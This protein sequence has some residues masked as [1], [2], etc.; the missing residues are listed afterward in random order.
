M[1]KIVV[2]SRIPSAKTA[3]E[4]KRMIAAAERLLRAAGAK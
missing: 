4:A 1:T 2:P 3:A